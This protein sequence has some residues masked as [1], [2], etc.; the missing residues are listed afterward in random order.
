LVKLY[1]GVPLVLTPQNAVGIE[2]REGTFLPRNTT[3]QCVKQISA[4]LDSAAKY[5]PATWASPAA[6]W[7][8]ITKGGAMALK[9][10]LLLYAASPQFNPTDVNTKWQAAY[11]ANKAAYDILTANGA[12]LITDYAK[13]WFTES[14]NTEAVFVTGYNTSV[15]DQQKRNSGWEASNRPKYSTV[16]GGGSNLPSWDMVKAYP[17]KDGKKPGESKYTYSDLLFF[18]DR[19]PRFEKTIAYNGCTWPMSN[20]PNNRLWTYLAAGKSVENG[21]VNLAIQVLLP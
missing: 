11:D 14:G 2:N 6:N 15:G 16:S 21:G 7:G 3:S 19:D 20:V 5:L 1:G 12:K 13:I 18:K 8:R 17:M 9:G 4:D 10:R